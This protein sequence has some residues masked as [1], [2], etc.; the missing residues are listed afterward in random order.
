MK[1][2]L[3][4]KSFRTIDF[5]KFSVSR[6]ETRCQEH[7]FQVSGTR[8]QV[9]GPRCAGSRSQVSGVRC[10]APGVRCQVPCAM[11]QVSGVMCLISGIRSHVKM[12]K[13]FTL[14]IFYVLMEITNL[15]S[16]QRKLQTYKQIFHHANVFFSMF[17][18]NNEEK[19]T[20]TAKS[21]HIFF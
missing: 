17:L 8:V 10:Q 15:F 6:F 5:G 13:T 18:R 1:G 14:K 16:S 11:L 7:R 21:F 4:K 12:S 19:N 20:A 9:P 2:H 3:R